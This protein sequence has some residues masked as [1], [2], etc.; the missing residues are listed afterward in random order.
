MMA[1]ITPD[2]EKIPY[3]KPQP[4]AMRPDSLLPLALDL[5]C[6]PEL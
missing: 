5:E 3:A 6:E 1:P 2:Q 4:F